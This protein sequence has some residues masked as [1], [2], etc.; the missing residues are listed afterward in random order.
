LGVRVRIG[1]GICIRIGICVGISVRVRIGVV[2][3]IGIGVRIGIAT[4]RIGI[5]I[6]VSI[7]IGR[8]NGAYSI[9]QKN[10]P[11]TTRVASIITKIPTQTSNCRLHT[12]SVRSNDEV[13]RTTQTT[14]THTLKAVFIITKPLSRQVESRL[15]SLTCVNIV[16]HNLFFAQ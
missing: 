16:Q 6:V 5:A 4:V 1:V 10:I 14:T 2:V 15:A 3:V 9:R 12:Q 7:R 11:R 8:W 13:I